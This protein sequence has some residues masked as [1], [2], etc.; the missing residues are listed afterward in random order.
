MCTRVF[1]ISIAHNFLLLIETAA[2]LAKTMKL[3]EGAARWAAMRNAIA[4]HE[5]KTRNLVDFVTKHGPPES[6]FAWRQLE[7]GFTL[8]NSTENETF[9]PTESPYISPYWSCQPYDD[10]FLCGGTPDYL[11]EWLPPTSMQFV[12][13]DIDMSTTELPFTKQVILDY[14][15]RASDALCILYDVDQRDTCTTCQIAPETGELAY[16]ST[17]CTNM[18][19]PVRVGTIWANAAHSF[20]GLVLKI[21]ITLEKAFFATH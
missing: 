16:D 21:P 4:S 19:R 10:A 9:A 15:A 11:Y 17:T 13:C 18:F 14:C 7:E 1:E 20:H 5:E 12:V 8:T 6:I 3:L 2:H